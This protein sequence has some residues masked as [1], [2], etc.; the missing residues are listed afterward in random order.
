MEIESRSWLFSLDKFGMVQGVEVK[1]YCS[2][3]HPATSIRFTRLAAPSVVK[4]SFHTKAGHNQHRLGSIF[5]NLIVSWVFCKATYNS[6]SKQCQ[7]RITS[8]MLW[9]S[10][11]A[12]PLVK[13]EAI[14]NGW[15]LECKEYHELCY[16]Q[17]TVQQNKCRS[18][19]SFIEG[20][21]QLY[22]HG[23]IASVVRDKI[24][25]IQV[26]GIATNTLLNN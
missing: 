2:N 16:S 9:C 10:A 12:L 20:T 1:W 5:H 15:V 22:L 24:R 3:A 18:C 7:V 4:Q 14:S 17:A 25:S 6:Y 8:W 23:V 21:E 19:S 26:H 13:L 11:S